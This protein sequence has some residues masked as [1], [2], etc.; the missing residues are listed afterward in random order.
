[1]TMDEKYLLTNEFDEILEDKRSG[2]RKIR[3]V[4]PMEIVNIRNWA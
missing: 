4:P 1:M 3:T 2:M